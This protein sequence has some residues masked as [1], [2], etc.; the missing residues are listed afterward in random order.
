[1]AKIKQNKFFQYLVESKQELA[2]VTWPSRKETIRYTVLVFGISLSVGVFFFVL[3]WLFNQG[4]NA[5]IKL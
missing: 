3:D 4:L 1:M 5:L 2:K